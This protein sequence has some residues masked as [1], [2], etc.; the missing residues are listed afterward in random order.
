MAPSGG[1]ERGSRTIVL[2]LMADPGLPEL[3]TTRLGDVLP[4][5]L[6]ENIDAAVRWEV[7]VIRETL[8]LDADG[9]MQLER[10]S[11]DL[12]QRHHWDLLVYVTDLPRY[13]GNE[14]LVSDVNVALGVCLISLPAL[15]WPRVRRRTLQAVLHAVA[16]MTEASSA[17]EPADDESADRLAPVHGVFSSARDDGKYSYLSGL[18]GRL[19]LMLG[20]IRSNQPGRLLPSLSSATAAAIGTGAFGIFYA[21]IWNMADSSSP[22]RL[23]G[24]SVLAVVSMTAWLIGYN[25]LW[26]RHRLHGLAGRAGMDNVATAIT[27]VLSVAAMYLI[28]FAVLFLGSLAVI[29]GDYLQSQLKHPVSPIDYARLA[30]L[31]S[32]LGTF[33]GALGSS[34]DSD[35]SIREATYS[36]RQ[37]ERRKLA[38]E[39]SGGRE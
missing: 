7:S 16:H 33:A 32:S 22:L 9:D 14:P 21:S 6:S 26:D 1:D 30:W 34:F 27:V 13:V 35:E 24:I 15:G 31:A 39:T 17:E 28:L 12:K 29:S 19:R 38:D 3:V 18:R 36:R 2:G 23:A 25:G 8:P 11:E 5:K 10:Y 37:Q 4:G 20:M